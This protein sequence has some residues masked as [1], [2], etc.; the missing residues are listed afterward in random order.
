MVYDREKAKEY[1][2]KNKEKA[3]EYAKQYRLDNKEICDLRAKNWN[4]NNPE[5]RKKTRI[6][7]DWKKVGIL[8]FDYNLLYDIYLSTTKCEN[9]DVELT[10]CGKTTITTRCLDHDHN[11]NDKFNVRGIL[12]WKC[13]INDAFK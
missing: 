11:I 3:K 8:C 9:C 6:I 1:R 2:E 7:S 12:C 10:T 13:N 4:K 5:A